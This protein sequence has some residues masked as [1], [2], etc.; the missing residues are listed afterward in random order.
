MLVFLNFG[1]DERGRYL[2]H[3]GGVSMFDT[4]NRFWRELA[5]RGRDHRERICRTN[6]PQVYRTMEQFI[7]PLA[8]SRECCL[9]RRSASGACRGAPPGVP[10]RGGFRQARRPGAICPR[11]HSDAAFLERADLCRRS[12]GGPAGR[13]ARRAFSTNSTRRYERWWRKAPQVTAWTTSTSTSFA[14]RV[15]AMSDASVRAPGPR[16]SPAPA[17]RRDAAG[18]HRQRAPDAAELSRALLR[19]MRRAT[20]GDSRARASTSMS[21]VSASPSI[22]VEIGARTYSLV[23]FGHRLPPEKRTDRVIAE[24]WDTTFVLHDG[25]PG[26]AE[27]SSGCR[28]MC[29][30]GGGA[31]SAE[32]ADPRPRQPQRAAV[33]PRRGGLEPK[34]DSPMR[35][36]S[37]PPAI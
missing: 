35:R 16:R 28:R 11:V 36:R 9:A 23:A 27:P 10:L 4:F 17:G 6:F 26:E 7:A 8:G 14:Q 37:R 12:L 20:A 21:A 5:E 22:A 31:L 33:R 18:A 34:A 2:G 30:A 25:A 1:I 29:R 19:R 3:T 24:E 15:S 13:G 32:R